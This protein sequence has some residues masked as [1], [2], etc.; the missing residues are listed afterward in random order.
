MGVD[1]FLSMFAREAIAVARFPSE[2]P[3]FPLRGLQQIC[4]D[5]FA[6][7]QIN[8]VISSEPQRIPA[9]NL[10]VYTRGPLF[11]QRCSRPVERVTL[12]RL[13]AFTP[14]ASASLSRA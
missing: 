14:D 9:V 2:N 10:R 7:R 11:I 1:F 12:R 5:V 3:P 8:K 4:V 13:L 6:V